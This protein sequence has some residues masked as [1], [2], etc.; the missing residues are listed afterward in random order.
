MAADL[1]SVILR[2]AALVLLLQASGAAVF[3]AVFRE[4]LGP[5]GDSLRRRIRAVALWAMV[6]IAAQYAL[7]AARLSGTMSGVLD[8]MLQRMVLGSPTA[9]VAALRIGA[10][11]LIIASASHA[12]GSRQALA[13]AGALVTAGSF[14]LV[15]HTTVHP[16]RAA[17]AGVLVVHVSAVLFWLGALWPLYRLSQPETLGT[18][19]PIVR[20]FSI[21]A[22]WIVPFILIA[23]ALLAFA[24]IGSVHALA[25][26]YGLMILVKLAAFAGLMVL[27]SANK[28]RLGPS[29]A[30]GEPWAV[31]P[32]RRSVAAEYFTIVCLLCLTAVLTT[33]FSP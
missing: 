30:R 26:T 28:W 11:G 6:A 8:P 31:R 15:G 24:L 7:E 21:L 32:F 29:L 2:A 27:A 14:V 22:A 17:L 13:A 33:F 3:L 16:A 5:L 10:L 1:V 25:Q 9:A 20:R 18:L 4:E 12:T 23:G 19:G